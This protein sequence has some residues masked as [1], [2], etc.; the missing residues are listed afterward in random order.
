MLPQQQRRQFLKYW[1]GG[2]LGSVAWGFLRPMASPSRAVDLEALCTATPLNARCKDY[3]PGVQ[4]RDR[5]NKPL[6]AKQLLS[7]STPGLPVRVQGLPEKKIAYLVITQ[8]PKLAEYAIRPICSHQGC[9][10]DWNAEIK[11]FI[12]PCHGA[13]FDNQGQVFKGPAKRALPL[14]T[15]VVKQDQVRLVDRAPAKDPRG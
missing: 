14:V 6:L 9:T 2:A 7:T 5:N 13:Q 3:L 4:A 11:R 1:V 8:G 15:V 10:V 12:C